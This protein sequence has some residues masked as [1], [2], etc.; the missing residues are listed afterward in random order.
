MLDNS[1]I[2]ATVQ[3]MDLAPQTNEVEDWVTF[4]KNLAKG[5]D[6]VKRL[7]LGYIYLQAK[8]KLEKTSFD[9]YCREVG[10][11]TTVANREIQF[12]R[13]NEEADQLEIEMPKAMTASK[14]AVTKGKTTTQKLEN[15]NELKDTLKAEPTQRQLQTDR[16]ENPSMGLPKEVIHEAELITEPIT[17]K[18]LADHTD[19][20]LTYK[21]NGDLNKA[22]HISLICTIVNECMETPT[23][24]HK[25]TLALLSS[26]LSDY[27][28]QVAHTTETLEG[29]YKNIAYD[30]E[31][32]M[33]DLWSVEAQEALNTAL[34][35]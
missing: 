35:N 17:I 13:A 33:F 6:E 5:F 3:A 8:K 21:A 15:Y 29:N 19:T 12:Y 31:S 2:V 27:R 34:V 22:S 16:K 10:T 24:A 14:L 25:G 9:D 4:T 18:S 23:K 11:S 7:G 26:S 20:K 28:V 30:V 1:E 32:L